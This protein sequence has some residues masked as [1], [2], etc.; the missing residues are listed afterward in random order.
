MRAPVCLLLCFASIQAAA[1][2]S[3]RCAA[4]SGHCASRL[5]RQPRASAEDAEA[6]SSTGQPVTRRKDDGGAA[7]A[8]ASWGAWRVRAPTNATARARHI[9]VDSED[10]A[11]AL[12]KELSFGAEL[13]HLAAEHS[14]CPSK[15]AGGDLG[16]FRPGDMA[17]EFD[18]FVFAESSPVG[19]PLGPVRTPF[20]YHVIV[21]DERTT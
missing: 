13:G 8:A 7:L 15:Q 11:L 6:L 14:L 12:L 1:A 9:L 16:S 5:V 10:K 3:L 2:F 21:I 4:W 18:A 19:T 20:G 17:T